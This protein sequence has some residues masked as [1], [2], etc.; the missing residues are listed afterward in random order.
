MYKIGAFTS[1]DGMKID[2]CSPEF[3]GINNSYETLDAAIKTAIGFESDLEEFG[4]PL[5]TTYYVFDTNEE[6]RIVW[7]AE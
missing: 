1:Q 6:D 2:N 7:T 5:D 4:L 3:V